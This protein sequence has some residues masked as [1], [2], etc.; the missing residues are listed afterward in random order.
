MINQN[1]IKKN[2]QTEVLGEGKRSQK[3]TNGQC[4]LNYTHR[5]STWYQG[6]I[7]K[8]SDIWWHKISWPW[9]QGHTSRSKVRD[10]EVSAFSECFYSIVNS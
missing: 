9:G 10:V 6:T 1:K 3:W 4:K 7:K 5:H 8:K 2:E